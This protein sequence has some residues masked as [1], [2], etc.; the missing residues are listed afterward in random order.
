MGAVLFDM[1]G[2]L[3]DSE[4]LWQRTEAKIVASFG[5]V[6]T[7]EDGETLTGNSLFDSASLMIQ[8]KNLPLEP[9]TAVEMMVSNM[10]E[11]YTLEGVPWIPGAR[12]L[13]SEL[14]SAQIPTALVSAS[15]DILVRDV[16][17]SAPQGSLEVMVTGSE[18]NMRQKPSGD[19]Y[20]LAARRLNVPIENCL[21]V[22]DSAPGLAAGQ[23]AGARL[24]LVGPREVAEIPAAR[25]DSVGHLRLRDIQELLA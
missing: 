14:A 21:V 17:A 25:F 2:T 8:L 16:C 20:R 9:G 22:E 11:L 10:H 24:A 12:E 23:D 18:P 19:P 15:Y 13:L 1:D 4:P 3:I 6:W 7:E 5:K